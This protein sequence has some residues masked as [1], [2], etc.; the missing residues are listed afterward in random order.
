MNKD[1]IYGN[2]EKIDLAMAK[3]KFVFNKKDNRKILTGIT[4][5]IDEEE[6]KNILLDQDKEIITLHY[7]KYE[8]EQ[9][10]W[11][12]DWSVESGSV[13]IIS[14]FEYPYIYVKS[15]SSQSEI[16]TL[17]CD[18]NADN[19]AMGSTSASF[20]HERIV[21]E[22]VVIDTVVESNVLSCIYNAPN[23]Q[24]CEASSQYALSLVTGQNVKYNWSVVGTNAYIDG[25]D[26][27][28]TVTI[29]T[30]S[31]SN[32]DIFTLR[33]HISDGTSLDYFEQEYSHSRSMRKHISIQDL[34]LIEK[35]S[36]FYLEDEP[37]CTATARYRVDYTGSDLPT[38]IKWY[39]ESENNDVEFTTA[40]DINIVEIENLGK[41]LKTNYKIKV[42]I[43]DGQTTLFAEIVDFFEKKEISVIAIEYIYQTQEGSCDITTPGGTCESNSVYRAK[44]IS[45]EPVHYQ[46]SIIGNAEIIGSTTDEFVNIQSNSN[47]TEN[48]TIGL[49]VTDDY[50]QSHSATANFRHKRTNVVNIISLTEITSGSCNF[51]TNH[52]CI[53]TSTYI[54]NAEYVNKYKWIIQGNAII[55]AGHGTH[56]IE[57]QS[58]G[59]ED[60]TFTVTC[61]CTGESDT[62]S[63][64]EVFTHD[65]TEIVVS[66]IVISSIDENI[67]GSCIYPYEDVCIANST[68]KVIHTGGASSYVWTIAGDASILSGQETDEVIVQSSGVA[69]TNFTL[70]VD[71][72]NSQYND[73]GSANFTHTRTEQIYPQIVINSL[74]ETVSGFC[75][76][77]EDG[78]CIAKSTY[79]IDA[80][81]YDTLLWEITGD[82]AIESGQGTTSIIVASTGSLNTAF[83][84]KCT[85]SNDKYTENISEDFI[86][87]REEE[88][89]EVF[90]K[91]VTY[92]ENNIAEEFR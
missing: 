74:T 67:T 48:F 91:H 18:I 66:P 54:I 72:S 17:S 5:E 47:K 46:W 86:H 3:S 36:C 80:T 70:D 49:V 40:R 62:D 85:A 73:S 30:N 50:T 61:T 88:I 14:S 58:D 16:F 82:I 92:D 13:E 38:S 11:S 34:V 19:I 7:I 4:V 44:I 87:T 10:N 29:K 71:V 25:L 43:T 9:K 51:E 56:A 83:N 33:C 39:I 15:Y 57:V 55:T 31:R 24:T 8:E 20:E 26:E 22:P 81:G 23:Q 60:E 76:Y 42:K 59:I 35:I 68:H 90:E 21:V 77:P 53:A 75:I 65:R 64:S 2:R 1:L 52:E 32:N 89:L 28:S 41:D 84:I 78:T 12:Y 27:Q 79:V 45:E 69:D 37:G 63:I 6:S